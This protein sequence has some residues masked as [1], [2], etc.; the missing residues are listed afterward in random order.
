MQNGADIVTIAGCLGHVNLNTTQKYTHVTIV[1]VTK[2]YDKA[3]P[4]A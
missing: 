3:H 2:N 1:E 4:R